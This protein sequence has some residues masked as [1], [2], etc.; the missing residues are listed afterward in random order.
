MRIYAVVTCINPLR[1]YLFEEGLAR[2]ATCKYSAAAA[3]AG[4]QKSKYMHLTNYSIN[5]KN[6]AYQH[7]ND[8]SEG[9][10]SKWSLT[11]LRKL[12]R[13]Q[14]IDDKAIWKSIED[15]IIKTILA[16]EPQMNQACDQYVPSSSNCF[17]LFG[18]DI[19]IDDML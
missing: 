6:A 5:K 16:G 1:I 3:A 19:M 2:F 10:G 11:A 4:G 15:I 12:M 9:E 17:E 13:E 7:S 8:G 18:F 14:G